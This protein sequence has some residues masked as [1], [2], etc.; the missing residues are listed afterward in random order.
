MDDSRESQGS[1]K[2]LGDDRAD[3]TSIFDCLFVSIVMPGKCVMKKKKLM[4]VA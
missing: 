4:K 1:S 3:S 2:E